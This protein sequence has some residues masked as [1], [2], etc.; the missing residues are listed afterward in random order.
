VDALLRP[1]LAAAGVTPQLASDSELCRR[2]SIDLG[3][4]APT[5][6]EY[7]SMCKGRTPDEM[8]DAFMARSDYLKVA[9]R[10]W[11][12]AL[13][14]DNQ[15]VW[16]AYIVQLGELTDALY[17]D[18][19]RYPDFVARVV[20]HPGFL[21]K[22]KGE[23]AVAQ[24][25]Q[26]FLGRDA[27]PEERQDLL[28][29]FR[30]WATRAALDPQLTVFKY[31]KCASN[32]D[33]ANGRVCQMGVCAD[34][35]NYQELYVD[36]TRCGGPV[37]RLLCSS[38]GFGVT[39]A[40]GGN[41]PIAFA[42][43]TAEQREQLA[44]P[45]RI[46]AGQPYFWEAAVDSVL[47]T[48]LGWWHGGAQ[49][50]GYEL[51]DIRQA[52]ARS[53]AASGSLRTLE[54]QVLTSLLYTMG[55]VPDRPAADLWDAGPTKLMPAEAWLD[56]VAS[57]TG[58]GVGGCDA[59]FPQT[60]PRYLPPALVPPATAVAGFDYVHEARLLGGCPDNLSQFRTT[61]TGVLVTL[62]QRQIAALLC[63]APGAAES[64]WPDGDPQ[65][66]VVLE[67]LYHGALTAE[68]QEGESG[69]LALPA[70]ADAAVAQNL[71]QALVRSGRF[72]FY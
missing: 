19:L 25:Y 4:R 15:T 24:A 46:I 36:P 3:G 21:A 51:P 16:Y 6:D 50:P 68:P 53:L 38:N 70:Q 14:F 37:T 34:T 67:H 54:R 52:L 42:D 13:G 30:Q 43:L 62:E 33:C 47:A 22:W 32:T 56:S 28:G 57:L 45:G 41:A 12:D 72:L 65:S 1:R 29:L 59:R 60:K 63:G 2:Y 20:S 71:C 5:W 27:L 31:N 64:L 49:L 18:A 8:V 44:T 55:S 35:H 61:T 23:N 58:L 66:D 39:V 10:R 26:V 40:L 69:P 48:Y 17:S 7:E 9:R 11:G